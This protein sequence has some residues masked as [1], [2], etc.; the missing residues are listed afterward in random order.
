MRWILI[1][2]NSEFH[3]M[4]SWTLIWNLQLRVTAITFFLLFFSSRVQKGLLSGVNSVEAISSISIKLLLLFYQIR[5]RYSRENNRHVWDFRS[6]KQHAKWNAWLNSKGV[7]RLYGFSNYAKIR[8]SR[9]IHL[10]RVTTI[11]FVFSSKNLNA[12][13]FNTLEERIPRHAVL[14]TTPCDGNTILLSLFFLLFSLHA[15]RKA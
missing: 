9:Q 8:V 6:A 10:H 13:D 7:S 4:L 5:Y 3:A 15:Y 11:W 1:H 14:A 2:L 12:L